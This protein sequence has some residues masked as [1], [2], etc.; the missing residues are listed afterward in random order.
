VLTRN[1]RL[2]QAP[3]NVLLS[4]ASTGLLADSVANVSQI[5]TLD[6]AQLTNLVGFVSARQ[7]SLVFA[8][9]DAVFGR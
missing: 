8:G 2:T 7:L 4:A 5:A 1:L 9:I 3:G 6:R